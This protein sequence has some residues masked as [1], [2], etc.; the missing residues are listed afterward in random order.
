EYVK[1]TEKSTS[2]NDSSI[3]D[4][5]ENIHV[6]VIE[7][8]ELFNNRQQIDETEDMPVTQLDTNKESF[9]Q[10][11]SSISQSSTSL[12]SVN[13]VED[14]IDEIDKD[15]TLDEDSQSL[16]VCQVLLR[17]FTNVQINGDPEPIIIQSNIPNIKIFREV[18]EK[19]I[20]FSC[21]LPVPME[22]EEEDDIESQIKAI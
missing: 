10:L 6:V 2:N 22:I 9:I 4:F 11:N 17:D 1:I 12:H 8:D 3:D 14:L 13:Q 18:F 15:N 21:S 19:W 5:I 16:Q 7:E 20:E